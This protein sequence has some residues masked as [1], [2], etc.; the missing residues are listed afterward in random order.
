LGESQGSRSQRTDGARTRARIL[1]VA[2][3]LFA[4]FGY[5]GTSIRAIA[6]GAACNVATLSYH[7]GGKEGLYSTVVQSLHRDLF[8]GIPAV[9]TTSISDPVELIETY[10]DLLWTFVRD[11]R[12]HMRLG[13]RHVLDQGAHPEVVM[14]NWS[15]VLMARADALVVLFRP[16]WPAAQ[17]RLLVSSVQHLLVRFAIEDRDQLSLLLGEPDDLDQAMRD[18]FSGFIRRELG[19]V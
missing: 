18:W 5:S 9:A 17:R 13:V 11:H 3:P 8:E 1:E 2:L 12:V 6:K 15:T 7:F 14:E 19:I 16:E 10:I 4:E